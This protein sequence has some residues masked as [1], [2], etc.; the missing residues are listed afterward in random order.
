[1]YTLRDHRDRFV[2]TAMSP[3][4][5]LTDDHKARPTVPDDIGMQHMSPSLVNIAN[6]HNVARDSRASSAWTSAASSAGNSQA[7]SEV[8]SAASSRRPSRG[9]SVEALNQEDTKPSNPTNALTAS[10]LQPPPTARSA[11]RKERSSKPYNLDSRPLKGKR[12]PSMNRLNSFT[13]TPLNLS[14]PGSPRQGAQSPP[15]PASVGLTTDYLSL[16]TEPLEDYAKSIS[17]GTTLATIQDYASPNSSVSAPS[18]P[19][20]GLDVYTSSWIGGMTAP[21]AQ[22]STDESSI[23]SRSVEQSPAYAQFAALPNRPFASSQTLQMPPQS[24]SHTQSLAQQMAQLG[25]DG[26]SMQSSTFAPALPRMS[27]IIPSEGPMHGGI[28]VTIL[29]ENFVPGLEVTF[30]EMTAVSTQAWGANTLV[31]VLPPS[32]CSGPVMVDI[33][34]SYIPAGAIQMQLFTYVDSGDKRLMELALQV[35]GTLTSLPSPFLLG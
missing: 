8:S 26:L 17:G 5:F 35:V 14:A 34:G 2:A 29:G 28:E 20:A 16:T 11:T 21:D 3:P 30:G 1:M 32:P 23:G 9:N 22:T 31:C 13:M 27:R 7:G 10:A 6:G 15:A 25:M 12:V 33:K 4:I 24:V 19:G 18:T